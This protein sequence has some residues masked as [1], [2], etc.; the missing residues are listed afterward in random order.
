MIPMDLITIYNVIAWSALVM[1]N[2]PRPSLQE[3][4]TYSNSTGPIF[5]FS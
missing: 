1:R 3:K 2:E 4:L 5:L